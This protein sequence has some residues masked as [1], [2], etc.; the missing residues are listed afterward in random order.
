MRFMIVVRANSDTEAGVMPGPEMFEAMGKFNEQMID[1]GIMLAADGLHP[2]NQ[3]ARIIQ[4]GGK[5]QVIDGPFAE[6]KELIA[7]YWIIQVKDKGE[8]L[9]WATRVPG[10]AEGEYVDLF[11]VFE[12][13]DFAGM[14]PDAAIAKEEAF[15]A[16]HEKPITG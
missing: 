3:G 7:G 16:A 14:V 15:R 11:R 12:A 6:T 10:M 2:S 5:P 9:S 8:A 13:A 4:K 1:A